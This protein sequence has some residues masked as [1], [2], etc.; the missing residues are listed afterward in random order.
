MKNCT[1]MVAPPS[2][3]K[4]STSPVRLS[5]PKAGRAV[6]RFASVLA[7]W[8]SICYRAVG[9][10]G[11]PLFACVILQGGGGALPAICSSSLP[12]DAAL[13]CCSLFCLPH[14]ATPAAG[15]VAGCCALSGYLSG[16][17]C[18]SLLL[19]RVT[20]YHFAVDTEAIDTVLFTSPE[21]YL[22]MWRV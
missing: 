5:Q 2:T 11:L 20:P 12:H 9:A 22:M 1:L 17:P 18:E 15:R 13:L 4:A 3:I 8:P 7:V 14:D 19:C 10:A 21:R 6:Y 16:R